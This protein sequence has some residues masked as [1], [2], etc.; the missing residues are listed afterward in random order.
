[1]RRLDP[2]RTQW[3]NPEEEEGNGV[4][5]MEAHNMLINWLPMTTA[6]AQFLAFGTRVPAD[7]LPAYVHAVRMIDNNPAFEAADSSLV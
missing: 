3:N 6:E 5:V 1:M 2:L 4:M 7:A